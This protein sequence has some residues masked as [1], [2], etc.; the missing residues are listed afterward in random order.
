MPDIYNRFEGIAV[1]KYF[2]GVMPG[3]PHR[4]ILHKSHCPFLKENK[5]F[6][7]I[8]EFCNARLVVRKLAYIHLPV[9]RCNFCCPWTNARNRPSRFQM[10]SYCE[11]ADAN[12]IN[13]R[14]GLVSFFAGVN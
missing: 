12:S 3:N 5:S 2:L 13:R 6:S 10:V 9:T 11:M 4:Y 1:N 8:G 14:K 7:F